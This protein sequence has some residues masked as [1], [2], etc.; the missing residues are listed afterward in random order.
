MKANKTKKRILDTSVKL[1]NEKKSSNVS[2]VQ[3]SAV[4]G[5]SPGNLYYYYANKEEVIRCIWTEKMSDELETVLENSRKTE[6]TGELLENFRECMEYCLRYKFFYTEMATLFANDNTL[7]D[8]YNEKEYSIRE[9]FSDIYVKFKEKGLMKD[10]DP[11]EISII[12]DNG[13]KLFIGVAAYCD[14]SPVNIS[15]ED[16][17][18]KDLWLRMAVYLKPMMTEKMNREFYEELEKRGV[19]SSLSIK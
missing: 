6:N 18:I 12:V 7:V 4:M 16:D 10:K 17:L 1:F 14:I 13:M 11:Q 8:L 3:I 9:A 5:I 2:T 19:K 15:G